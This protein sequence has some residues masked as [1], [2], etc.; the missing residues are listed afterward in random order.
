MSNEG[1]LRRR[2]DGL[3]DEVTFSVEARRINGN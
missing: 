3:A 2:H 1:A